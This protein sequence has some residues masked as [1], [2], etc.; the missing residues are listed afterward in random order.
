MCPLALS[1]ETQ[2][3]KQRAVFEVP[4][5][6]QPPV[7]MSWMIGADPEPGRAAVVVDAAKFLGLW[8]AEPYPIHQDLAFGNPVTWKADRKF[9]WAERGFSEGRANP[10]PLAYVSFGIDEQ[11]EISYRFLW[12]GKQIRRIFAAH[13]RFTNGITRTIW[14]LS[15]GCS[16]FPIESDLAGAHKILEH[17]GAPGS[18]VLTRSTLLAYAPET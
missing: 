16:A 15:N 4:L 10:V 11:F 9:G 14:L 8:Q 17:A 1:V 18:C 2:L 12:F 5:P 6:S 3:G 7:Y 13:V